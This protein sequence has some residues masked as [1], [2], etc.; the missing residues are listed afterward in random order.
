MIRG[1]QRPWAGPTAGQ[2]TGASLVADPTGWGLSVSVVG[3]GLTVG[4][5]YTTPRPNARRINFVWPK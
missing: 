4:W 2:T 5:S 1:R 3:Y